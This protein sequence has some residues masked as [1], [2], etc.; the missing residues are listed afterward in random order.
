M[1]HKALFA[2]VLV[3]MLCGFSEAFG[4]LLSLPCKRPRCCVDEN[5]CRYGGWGL[6]NLKVCKYCNCGSG[7]RKKSDSC[8]HSD[9]SSDFTEAF[10]LTGTKLTSCAKADCTW[11]SSEYKCHSLYVIQSPHGSVCFM[12][13]GGKMSDQ[14]CPDSWKT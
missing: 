11:G 7:C 1:E 12:E 9:Y 8:R 6:P 2:L 14:K 3:A 5:G 4:K 13:A 10:G